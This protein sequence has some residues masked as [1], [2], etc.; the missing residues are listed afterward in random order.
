MSV[1]IV[2]TIAMVMLGAVT[3]LLTRDWFHPAAIFSLA[4]ACFCGAGLLLAPE[5]ITSSSAALWIL[6]N[7]ALVTIGGVAGSAFAH[8]GHRL[9]AVRVAVGPPRLRICAQP[10]LRKLTVICIFL[11]VLF[12]PL[13]LRAQGIGL[14][15]L[16]SLA[17]W[18]RTAMR[19]TVLRY[20][21]GGQPIPTYI[22]LLLTASYLGP[23]FGGT[24]FVWRRKFS[25]SVLSL[26][27]MLPCAAG[28]AIQSTKASV[29]YGATMWT[30]GYLAARTYQ[31]RQ[32]SRL[33]LQALGWIAVTV[34]M[35]LPFLAIGDLLRGGVGT[36]SP[37]HI[38][39]LTARAKTY[40]G[41]H[42][43]ALSQ[44]LDTTDLS[45]IQPTFGRYTF[46]GLYQYA[47]AA[48]RVNGIFE[49]SVY[50]TTGVT[51]VYTYFRPL[52][53]DYTQP[54]SLLVM[55]AL[56]FVGGILYRRA[57]EGKTALVGVLAAYYAAT[58]FG[59]TSIFNYNSLL[60]AFVLYALWWS[61]PAQSTPQHGVDRLLTKTSRT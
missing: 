36:V 33:R 38:F 41:G 30:A 56:A 24:L 44:W 43:P 49:E 14:G 4:W 10:A 25:D 45:G 39:L 60:L 5:N 12:I 16:T 26:L 53:Q 15:Q 50:I 28:F 34:A 37:L 47:H 1:S 13:C 11:G 9:R 20:S 29:L 27:T 19:M 22:E 54:G 57:L 32:A 48:D 18:G 3:K 35:L 23:L 42:V 7:A 61:A 46:A 59:V 51:N 31:G 58:L 8:S 6:L 52:I 17:G 40:L 2:A 21:K 55:L